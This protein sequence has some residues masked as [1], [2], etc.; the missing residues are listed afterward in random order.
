MISRIVYEIGKSC[1]LGGF[2]ASEFGKHGR[3][4]EGVRLLLARLGV[5]VSHGERDD[6]GSL[7]EYVRRLNEEKCKFVA[8]IIVVTSKP[9]SPEVVSLLKKSKELPKPL[10]FRTVSPTLPS[11]KFKILDISSAELLY[12]GNITSN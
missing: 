6:A 5:V 9:D 10:N 7:A 8:E 1:G 12:F 11:Y 4:G 2:Y 3:V